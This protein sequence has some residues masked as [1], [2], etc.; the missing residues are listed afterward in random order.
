[1][2]Q[3]SWILGGSVVLVSR[4]NPVRGSVHTVVILPLS[5]ADVLLRH[6]RRVRRS[7]R[8]ST[9]LGPARDST[10]RC[11]LIQEFAESAG[12]PRSGPSSRRPASR[13]IGP[14]AAGWG[15]AEAESSAAARKRWRA[16]ERRAVSARFSR[17]SGHWARNRRMC[18]SAPPVSRRAGPLRGARRTRPGGTARA[19]CSAVWCAARADR[20]ARRTPAVPRAGYLSGALGGTGSVRVA[21]PPR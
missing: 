12:G 18:R 11:T 3:A 1:L 6:Q 17:I 20:M 5:V 8:H 9:E 4:R 7:P 2:P 16:G 15:L 13:S 21:A 14:R 19:W 10:R